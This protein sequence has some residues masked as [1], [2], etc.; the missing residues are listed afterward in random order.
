MAILQALGSTLITEEEL[1]EK[2]AIG[3]LGDFFEATD[4]GEEATLSTSRGIVNTRDISEAA[5]VMHT[6]IG[7]GKP[8]NVEILCFYTGEAP[9]RFLGGKPDLL[10]SSAVKSHVTHDI[11]PLAINQLVDKIENKVLIE[12]SARSKGSPIV[13]YSPALDA[14]TTL[15]SFQMVTESFNKSSMD[16]LGQLMGKA[17][18]MPVFAPASSILMAGSVIT[19][20]V[21]NIG[22]KLAE[23][24]PFLKEDLNV[25]LDT[26]G[27]IETQAKQYVIVNDSDLNKIDGFELRLK[28]NT[29]TGTNRVA[30]CNIQTGKEY[31]GSAPYIV[32]NVDGKER[33]E[34]VNFTPKLAASAVLERFYKGED[35]SGDAVHLLENAMTLYNDFTY[36]NKALKM[37]KDMN[38]MEVGS[39][40]FERSSKLI[41]A[42]TK[43]ITNEVFKSMIS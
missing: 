37:K 40:A 21:G 41:D 32:V 13:F 18:G 12:P 9:S 24:R 17:S 15:C 8:I 38:G 20:M 36:Y 6:P 43:N 5:P 29:A 1:N 3:Q 31:K 10:V 16:Q 19:K 11:A 35:S 28:T 34:L 25:R 22:K 26:A 4:R 27:L 23:T 7:I 42:Y 30:L 33:P 14:S 2:R 39:K